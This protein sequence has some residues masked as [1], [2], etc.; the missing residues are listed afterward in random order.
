MG[1]PYALLTEVA[2]CVVVCEPCHK[3]RHAVLIEGNP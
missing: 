2:K 3:A 1:K